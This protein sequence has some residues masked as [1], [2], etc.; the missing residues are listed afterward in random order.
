MIVV[1][2]KIYYL[3]HVP[4]NSIKHFQGDSEAK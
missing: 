3:L 1:A 4:T 2:E